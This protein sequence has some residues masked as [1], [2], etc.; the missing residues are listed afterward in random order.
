MASEWLET[1]LG[2]VVQLQ[3]GHDLPETVRS[4]G[5]VPVMGSF[6]ITG[7]HSEPIAKGPGVTVG[8]SGASIGVVSYV[9]RDYWP[10]N[11]C[12]Y[13]TDFKGNDP[14][15]CY[16]WLKT[17]KLAEYN[18]GSAQPSLNRNYI[19]SKPVLIPKF[20]KEQHAIADILSTLD[21]KIELN[22]KISETL[23]AMARALFKSWF[24][25]FDPVHAKAEGRDTG[26]PDHIAAFFPNSFEDSSRGEIP[27]GWTV[28]GLDEI[29]TFLNGLALQKYPAGEGGSLPA[30][31]IAQLRSGTTEGADRVSIDIPPAYRVNDGDVLFSWSGSLECVVWTSGP[32]ALNQ[33]L[34]KVTSQQYPKW[35]YLGWIRHHLPGFK[36]IA[37]AKATTMG[38]IQRHHLREALVVIPPGTFVEDVSAIFGDF[39]TFSINVMLQCRTLSTLRDSL[40]PKLLSGE[41]RVGN[42]EVFTQ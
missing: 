38:H 22:K 25:D 36:A 23:D 27:K 8:R 3:R 24:V 40:L 9:E 10:L 2:E 26:L 7:W 1:V 17:L 34:F 12:L 14:K 21:D 31:K 11:T 32:G 4:L 20:N 39:L 28:A 15:F 35:F 33:H 30:I 41:L 16:Y 29:G 18:S 6:G 42:A 5:N 13:V 19:Y 37:A